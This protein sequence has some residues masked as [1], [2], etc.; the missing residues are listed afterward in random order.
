M[1]LEDLKDRALKLNDDIESFMKEHN[2]VYTDEERME[3]MRMCD[4]LERV[5]MHIEYRHGWGETAYL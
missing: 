1:N 4:E 5:E 2:G 3:L